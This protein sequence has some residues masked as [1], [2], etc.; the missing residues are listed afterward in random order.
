MGK[1]SFF[2]V[3]L[4][5]FVVGYVLLVPSEYEK[6]MKPAI[7]KK[8]KN[9]NMYFDNELEPPLPDEDENSKTIEG[10]DKNK[11]GVRDDVEIWINRTYG[12]SDERK[13]LMQF[14]RSFILELQTAVELN[15]EKSFELIQESE[16]ATIC[17]IGV[18]KNQENLKALKHLDV[19]IVNTSHRKKAQLLVFELLA[20]K[21]IGGHSLKDPLMYCKFSV[22]SGEK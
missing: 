16:K 22:L 8:E 7:E 11:N 15:K 3:A 2:V 4:L 13:A 12:L 6:L 18:F 21:F 9:P 1:K 17:M 20:G 5:C 10:V 19:L 14:S